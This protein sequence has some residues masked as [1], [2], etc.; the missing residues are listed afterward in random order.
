ML[1]FLKEMSP[2]NLEFCY[3]FFFSTDV[4]IGGG[5]MRVMDRAM[6]RGTC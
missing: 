2:R 6:E 5:N 1:F 4:E 3:F